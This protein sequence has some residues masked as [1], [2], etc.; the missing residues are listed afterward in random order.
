LY[1]FKA[2]T[3]NTGAASLNVNSLG[4]K[5][6]KKVQ[7]G[8]TTDLDTNDIRSGQFVDC[9]Y[10]GTNMQMQSTLGNTPG[11]SGTTI[12]ST[13]NRI[14]YRSNA[15]T[16]ADSYLEHNVSGGQTQSILGHF[17][18]S[19]NN[20]KVIGFG[21]STIAFGGFKAGAIA[22]VKVVGDDSGNPGTIFSDWA[23]LANP[24]GN[25]APYMS[26]GMNFY[27]QLTGNITMA[28]PAVNGGV[29]VVDGYRFVV[30][31][32][33]NGTGGYTVTWDSAFKF[34]GGT[35]PT[36]TTAANAVDLYE[37]IV[38]GGNAYSVAVRQ[39]LK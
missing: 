24:G 33:N 26:L 16:F 25:W 32:Q 20:S 19:Q 14:P 13:D 27:K 29:G 17:M 1:R 6:I 28:A 30:I 15:T 34:P 9:V 23:S 36:Q 22:S 3:A 39:D 11:G 4:A 12:N 37:F 38:Y 7:G 18:L 5:T 21:N 8:I 2:N 31:L 10:D 35:A